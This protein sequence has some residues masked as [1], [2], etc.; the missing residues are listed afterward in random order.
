MNRL[1]KISAIEFPEDIK[2]FERILNERGYE[3]YDWDLNDAWKY[4]STE[5]YAANW[6]NPN[7]F[8]DQE[9]FDVLK[10]ELQS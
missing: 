5:S 6:M 9:I 2:R 7:V 4:F 3:A 10:D 8:T 1:R